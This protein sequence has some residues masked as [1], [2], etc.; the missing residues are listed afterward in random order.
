MPRT[1][2][3]RLAAIE[4]DLRRNRGAVIVT[5]KFPYGNLT[6][7]I[8]I[9]NTPQFAFCSCSQSFPAILA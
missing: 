5:V 8:A 2:W 3:T 1:P 7:K 9:K 6:F 4:A